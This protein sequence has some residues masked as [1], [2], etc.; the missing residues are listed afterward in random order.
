MRFEKANIKNNEQSYSYYSKLLKE[1][2]DSV[3]ELKDAEEAYYAKLKAKEDKAAQ[4]K[5]DALAVEDAF[6]CLNAA[7]KV[8]KEKLAEI[9]TRYSEDLKNL[10]TAFEKDREDIQNTL[11]KREEAYSNALKTF[12]EKYPEGYHITLKDGD[13]ETTISSH[14]ATDKRPYVT[15]NILDWLFNF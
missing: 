2:F 9:T 5:A 11:A 4:K 3:D 1:P 7:R 8:Y 10:K 6:K 15:T 12:T 14:T 13:F